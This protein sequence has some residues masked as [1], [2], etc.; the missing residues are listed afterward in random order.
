MWTRVLRGA[1]AGAAGTT[2]LNAATYLDMTL[3]GRP[4]SSTPELTV[5]KLSDATGVDVPGADDIRSNRVNGISALLGIATGVAVG[6]VFGLVDDTSN[7]ALGRLPTM[8]GGLLIGTVALVGANGP[9]VALGVSDPRDWGFADWVSDVLP[10]LAY[11]LVAG[12]TY[13]ALG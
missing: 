8:T 9:M 2:A 4:T 12:F 13:H 6:A 7:G 10:H 3:R 11:G 1:V 5:E